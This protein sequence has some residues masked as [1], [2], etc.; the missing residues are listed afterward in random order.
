MEDRTTQTQRPW[1]HKGPCQALLGAKRAP[2][3]SE[4]AGQAAATTELQRGASCL[5]EGDLLQASV[6]VRH[7]EEDVSVCPRW[8]KEA[9]GSPMLCP[10]RETNVNY[11]IGVFCPEDS[12]SACFFCFCPF[13]HSHVVCPLPSPPHVP[14]LVAAQRARQDQT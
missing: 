3:S 13:A 14:C 5:G 4:Q 1:W 9:L 2:L 12:L 8:L 6:W 11:N 10:S 7:L